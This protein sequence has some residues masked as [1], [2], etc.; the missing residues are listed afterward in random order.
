ML[1]ANST[2]SRSLHLAESI[3]DGLPMLRGEDLG[4]IHLSLATSSRK[5]NMM[6]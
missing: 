3:I 6:F 2:T 1:Q 4:E 5:A